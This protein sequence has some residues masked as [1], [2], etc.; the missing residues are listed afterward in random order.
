MAQNV[1][2]HGAQFK[3]SAN[4]SSERKN[5]IYRARIFWPI[6]LSAQIFIHGNKVFGQCI[7]LHKQPRTIIYLC[8]INVGQYAQ[9]IIREM[10]GGAGARMK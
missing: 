8:Q 2:R 7:S 10:W 5:F 9:F 1:Y 3:H 6:N 4:S